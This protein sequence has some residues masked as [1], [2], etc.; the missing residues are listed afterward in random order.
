MFPD[1]ISNFVVNIAILMIIGY[2]MPRASFF[3]R[4]V[5]EHQKLT[6]EKVLLGLIFGAIGILATY[7][8]IRINGAIVNTRVIGVIAGG[9]LGG[10][11]V[12]IIAG[13]VAGLHR[14][15]IDI[16]GFTGLACAISTI[17]EGLIGGFMYKRVRSSKRK[18][19]IIFA[20]T[21]I[22][23]II[24][25]II[26]LLIA[27]PFVDAVELVRIIALPMII[28]NSIGIV[29]FLESMYS[30]QRSLDQHSAV[31]MKLAFDLAQM[32]LPYLRKGILHE[33][34]MAESANI[35][36]KN[37]DATAVL[38]TNNEK[39][40]ANAGENIEDLPQFPIFFHYEFQRCMLKKKTIMLNEEDLKK[41]QMNHTFKRVLIAPLMRSDQIIGTLAICDKKF[42]EKLEA[43]REFINGLSSLFS[44]QLELSE[45]DYQKKLLEKAEL[46]ALQYQ[47]NPHFLFNALNTIS[48]YCRENPDRARTL[49]L[50]LSS[51]F[52]NTLST[53]KEM[54]DIH[55]EIEHVL[56][57]LEIEK[58]RFEDRLQ[59]NIDVSPDL[60]FMVPNFIVQPLIEN[61]IKHG[62]KS[63]LLVVDVKIEEKKEGL[64]IIIRDNGGGIQKHIVEKLYN[65]NHDKDKIGLA[66]THHR[67]K[68]IYPNNAG[69]LIESK[70]SL[71]TQISMLIPRA[72]A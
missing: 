39:V 19:R 26:I 41:Y 23:E 15:A 4:T 53:H 21:F 35:I 37:I 6:R 13:L 28:L 51:Y 33:E 20:T 59:V 1:I 38:I 14:Y 12:G 45:I 24:Q 61:A 55:E 47:I 27:R 62:M 36:Y 56:S 29:V 25:M 50:A 60:H 48:A 8:G 17:V 10:P 49:L 9:F 7:T 42:K 40:L 58:A 67:L 22:A 2:L 3:R 32:C 54:V 71:G 18:Y 72:G 64:S 70:P 34:S 43:D 31:H 68:S 65:G 63:P 11:I 46:R 5:F 30:V 69:L 16:N 52:R 44:S 57:Y 66:N